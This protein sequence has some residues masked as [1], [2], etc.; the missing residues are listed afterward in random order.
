MGQQ[1]PGAAD[2]RTTRARRRVPC[3]L[4]VLALLPEAP[5]F[6]QAE[7]FVALI[8]TELTMGVGSALEWDPGQAATAVNFGL[9]R[10]WV[11]DQWIEPAL[12]MGLGP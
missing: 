4:L 8:P 12:E 5:A 1:T 3:A 9:S 6:A 10:A 2:G 7:A 11:R